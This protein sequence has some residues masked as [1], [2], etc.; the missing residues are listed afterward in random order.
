[1]TTHLAAGN[2]TVHIST[3]IHL[4]SEAAAIYVAQVIATG[5]R[6]SAAAGRRF[7]L[8]LPTGNTPIRVYQHLVAMHSS[9]EITFRH[10]VIFNLDEYHG[11][12]A[13]HPQSYAHF[14]QRHLIGHIDIDPDH[15]HIP[16]GDLPLEMVGAEV[17]AYEHALHDAGGADLAFLGIGANGH[18]GFNEPGSPRHARTR[19]TRLHARTR[20]DAVREFGT[21]DS[22][23]ERGIS[24][25]VA[26]IM[27]ARRILLLATGSEK[28]KALAAAVEGPVGPACP[29]S[30]LQEHP[31][32][33][34]VADQNAAAQF[35]AVRKPWLSGSIA[36]TPSLERAAAIDVAEHS[37]KAL[38]TCTPHDYAARGLL[39]LLE[40]A[41][42]DSLNLEAFRYLHA[43]IT[44][45]PGGKPPE[46]RRP[47]DITRPGDEI[48]PKTVVVFSPHPDDDVIGMGGTIAR[49]IEQG[50][51]VHIAYQTPG[52]RAV[53]EDDLDRHLAFTREALAIVGAPESDFT[54]ADRKRLKALIR[55]TEAVAAAGVVGVTSERLYFL[56]CPGYELN[57]F[58]QVDIE[59]H[60]SLL[61]RLR[62]H[63]IYTA[64]DLA[65]PNGTHLRC[66]LALQ[67]AMIAC[68]DDAWAASCAAFLYRGGWDG[69]QPSEMDMAVPLSEEDVL[70]KRQAIIRHQSQ[71]DRAMFLGEDDREFWQRAEDRTKGYAEILARLG[72]PRYAALECF[73]RWSW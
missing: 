30:F 59:L 18:I 46:R 12:P 34:V 6:S 51:H 72:M 39:E 26:S 56:D 48:H 54:G 7:V 38:L 55:R 70:R 1:M 11:L 10:A 69:F 20:R 22:V 19:L 24:M 53:H 33:T 67:A 43:S 35:E 23:P 28:A 41:S 71:K 40:K 3:D 44:G 65:D 5:L 36:W 32:A 29:A 31:G 2:G 61:R 60:V 64:G 57:A 37:G 27:G 58:G 47:G 68:K 62:P 8:I 4:N 42:V 15:V 45:W 49:L 13:G 16:R 25:G 17:A 50:H 66:L 14:M 21:L 73:A 63:Q 52:F 9:G